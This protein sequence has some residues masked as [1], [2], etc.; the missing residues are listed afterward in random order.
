[1]LVPQPDAKLLSLIFLLDAPSSRV[2]LG[3]KKR[4]FGMGKYNGFGGKLEPGETMRHVRPHEVLSTRFDLVADGA[5]DAPVF[6]GAIGQLFE[7]YIGAA[8]APTLHDAQELE[9]QLDGLTTAGERLLAADAASQALLVASHAIASQ[10][11]SWYEAKKPAPK[12]TGTAS[13]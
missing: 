5:N 7:A 2:L 1:M 10:K 6:G 11:E 9:L 3:M 8:D 4:G 13:R 12:Q